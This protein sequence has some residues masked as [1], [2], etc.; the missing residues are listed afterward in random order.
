MIN[1]GNLIDSIRNFSYNK[2]WIRANITH[3]NFLATF[4]YST[5]GKQFIPF[6]N[7]LNMGLGLIWTANRFAL[8]NFSATEKGEG[9]YVDFNW[10][11]FKG[12]TPL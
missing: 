3:K 7:T 5:D 6:G 4:S 11:H 12:E 9:G 8:F 1:D 10:F 2:L